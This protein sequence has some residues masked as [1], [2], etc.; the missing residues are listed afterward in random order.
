M[1]IQRLKKYFKLNQKLKSSK[2]F[3]YIFLIALMVLVN[4]KEREQKL[5]CGGKPCPDYFVN[6][7]NSSEALVETQDSYTSKRKQFRLD[8]TYNQPALDELLKRE[9]KLNLCLEKT[10]LGNVGV[11]REFHRKKSN[12]NLREIHETDRYFQD[13]LSEQNLA[14]IKCLTEA[15]KELDS[16]IAK[17]P[18]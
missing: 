17:Y 3:I 8:H 5:S 14:L 11:S 7:W 15:Q 2:W 12:S 10:P 18:I 16:L 6:Y 4:C 1:N 9:E 13:K